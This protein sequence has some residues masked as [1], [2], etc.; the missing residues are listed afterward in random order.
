MVSYATVTV[1]FSDE[2]HKDRR[3]KFDICTGVL[4]KFLE[5]VLSPLNRHTTQV[6]FKVHEP[7]LYQL[8]TNYMESGGF[9]RFL[10]RHTAQ[11]HF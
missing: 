4:Y 6:R 9:Q 5:E 10:D 1:I 7:T 11:G 3:L 2:F 8:A